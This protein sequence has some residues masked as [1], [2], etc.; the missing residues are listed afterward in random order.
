[1]DRRHDALATAARLV[2]GMRKAALEA[3]SKFTAGRLVTR[4]GVATVVAAEA[5]LTVD[6]RHNDPEVLAALLA[7]AKR[8]GSEIAAEEGVGCEWTH[9]W[10]IEPM[11]F[12]REL[13]EIAA[14]SVEEVA[15]SAPRMVSGAL[16]DAAEAVR[17]G[18]PTVMIFVRSLGG[19]SHTKA[20][21]S[22]DQDLE[23]AVRALART[24]ERSFE[25]A[26]KH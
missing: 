19:I 16:H 6:Q 23:L 5:D 21:D 7:A 4:P 14:A 3:G 18:V 20:E 22:L 25:L 26:T 17:A 10:G 13:I 8:L 1:M 2:L 9:L 11:A 15:G 24:V 12:D